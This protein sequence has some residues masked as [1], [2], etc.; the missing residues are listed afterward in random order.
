MND[1]NRHALHTRFL[2]GLELSPDRPAIRLGEKTVTY[3]EAHELALCWA[4]SLLAADRPPRVLGVLAGKSVEAY[5]GVLA[6]LYAGATVVPLHPDFPVSRTRHMLDRAAVTA[7]LA[8]ERGCAVLPDIFDGEPGLPVLAPSA[9]PGPRSIIADPAHALAVPREV[10][11]TDNAYMLFTSG[12]TGRPKGVPITHGSTAHYFGLLDERYDFGPRDVFS[13]TFDL[14]FDCAMFDL[15][16]AWGAGA[17]ICQ[18]P[19]QAY[20]DLPGFLVERAVSV[21]FSTPSAISLIRRMGGLVPGA[22][23]GLRWSFFAGEALRCS[24]AEQWQAAAPRSV[25]ENL[26]GPTELTVTVSGHRWDPERSPARGINGFAPIGRIHAGHEHLLLTEDDGT[27]EVE[28]E[29]C[30]TGPQLTAGYLDPADNAGRFLDR[31]GRTWYR[32]GDRVRQL[33][34]GELVYL[35]RLDSQVQIQGWRVELAEVEHALRGCPGVDEA[36]AVTRQVDGN[37][38]LAVFYTGEF[39][40]PAEFARRLRQVLP[41]GMLPRRYEQVAELPLNAN[42]KIDRPALAARANAPMVAHQHSA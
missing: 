18:V 13:Q 11:A 28:G 12:S 24:D 9:T 35:G 2:R 37:T 23:P 41:Q 38:E 32:T 7:L 3:A 42:R 1:S 34:D 22:M 20:R 29:L 17:A 4:G 19:A 16:C 14:N 36:V 40:A 27:S 5:V 6:G 39:T 31:D 25:V 15:F 8:D 33:D 21:W 10:A 30:I 26:Y